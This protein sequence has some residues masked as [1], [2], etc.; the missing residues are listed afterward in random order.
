[1]SATPVTPQHIIAVKT[2]WAKVTPIAE[3]AAALFYARLF[4]L[5]PV[6]K[7]LFVSDMKEQG[8]KLMGMIGIAV[9]SL[10]RID[11]I[12]PAVQALGIRHKAYGV[13]PK[14]YDTVAA[15]LLWTLDQGL[16]EEFTTEVEAAWVAVYGL[17][18]GAMQ[19][20]SA[21]A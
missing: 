4:E 18:A 7:G 2:S 20:A 13:K 12:V 8:R 9:N 14:D 15:A 16:G 5:D 21:A 1:M 10:D 3:E 17:L 6:L 11:E 19:D